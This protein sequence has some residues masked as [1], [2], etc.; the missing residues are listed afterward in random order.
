MAKIK[1]YKLSGVRRE[2]KRKESIVGEEYLK[3]YKERFE[4]I[5]KL[6]VEQHKTYI[7]ANEVY[8]GS[9]IQSEKEETPENLEEIIRCYDEVL[10]ILGDKSEITRETFHVLEKLSEVYTFY[11]KVAEKEDI[12]GVLESGTKIIAIIFEDRRINIID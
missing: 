11:G 1:Y 2:T 4:V 3:N 5:R 6:A 9:I 12:D 10:H 8:I 7:M